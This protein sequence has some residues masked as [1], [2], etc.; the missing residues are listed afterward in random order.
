MRNVEE[1]YMEKRTR[2]AEEKKTRT[3]RAS[4]PK[5]EVAF[6]SW[7]GTVNTDEGVTLNVRKGP[8]MN[9]EKLSECP[10]IPRGSKV[11]VIGESGEWLNVKVGG[12]HLGFVMAQFIKK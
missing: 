2:D 6:K 4:A 1:E 7:K 8:G 3:R 9:F 11:E 5:E 12:E 10:S